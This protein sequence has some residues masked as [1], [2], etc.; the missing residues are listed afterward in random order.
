MRGSLVPMLVLTLTGCQLRGGWLDSLDTGV[1]VGDAAPSSDAGPLRDTGTTADSGRRDA[2]RRDAGPAAIDGGSEHCN[3]CESDSRFCTNG[4][5][6]DGDGLIDCFDPS[7]VDESFGATAEALRACL[8]VAATAAGAPDLS[9]LRAWNAPVMGADTTLPV[10]VA[11]IYQG[12]IARPAATLRVEL[13]FPSWRSSC[14]SP[15]CLS[16]DVPSTDG[17]P[18]AAPAN[19]PFDS[20]VVGDGDYVTSIMYRRWW[21]PAPD[22]GNVEAYTMTQ[23]NYETAHQLLTG[24]DAERGTSV[25]TGR[26]LD[27]AGQDIFG[28]DVR[29][30]QNGT[31]ITGTDRD[32]RLTPIN[33]SFNAIPVTAAPEAAFFGTN[34]PATQTHIEVWGRTSPTEDPILIGCEELRSLPPDGFAF[35][36]I[37]PLRADYPADHHC[38]GR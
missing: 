16:L 4:E 3:N 22:T 27:C 28:L 14:D 13:H 2:G 38:A 21:A 24:H 6:D 5:D 36:A 37:P 11:L 17:V 20:V 12:G 18:I 25:I 19:A 7:C 31:R 35:V 26:V 29:T 10:R 23:D 34:L 1:A 9:C 33:S 8:P 30:Y 32:P 15:A